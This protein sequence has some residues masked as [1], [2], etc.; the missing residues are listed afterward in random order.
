MYGKKLSS[1]HR[2]KIS[3]ALS[4]ENHPMYGKK[5]SLKT[6]AK[7]STTKKGIPLSD[8]HKIILS[9]TT[10]TAWRDHPE[11]WDEAIEN[12]QGGDDI[13]N[14]HY[15]YDHDDLTKY[16]MRMTRKEHGKLHRNMQII[17]L[18]VPHINKEVE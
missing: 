3:E 12:M 13:V 10:A 15:I 11:A 1:G 4:G 18:K 7:I 6:I 5:H 17:G 2:A 8:A 16:I 9:T 14:H